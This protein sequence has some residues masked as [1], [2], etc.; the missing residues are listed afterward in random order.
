[1]TGPAYSAFV[2]ED[3][4]MIRMMLVEMLEELGHTVA[5]EAGLLEQAI[6]LARPI[7]ESAFF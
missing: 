2:V 4:T 3:E 1:M 6:E 7:R 5:A